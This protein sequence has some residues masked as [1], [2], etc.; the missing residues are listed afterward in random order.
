[1]TRFFFT[2]LAVA[3]PAAAWA[4]DAVSLT[5]TVLVER[6]KLDAQGRPTVA[7]E[8]P[9]V[10]VPGDKLVFHLNYRNAGATPAQDFTVTN[11]IPASV[12]F[13]AGDG[14]IVSVDGG[15]SWGRLAALKVK[16]ADGQPRAALPTDVTHVRWTLA[17]PIPAGGG[18]Q[19]SFRGIVK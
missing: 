13:T 3:S 6:Q 17:S 10:V 14:A 1:M 15:T 8:E 9:Q 16:G 19:L 4:A 11:P 7:L 5:S 18:G 2:F 12:S